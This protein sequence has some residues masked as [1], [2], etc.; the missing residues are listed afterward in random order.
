[1]VTVQTTLVIAI[2]ILHLS[3]GSSQLP[4]VSSSSASSKSCSWAI[5][6]AACGVQR[7]PPIGTTVIPSFSSPPHLISVHPEESWQGKQ[8]WEE[9]NLF[10]TYLPVEF[11]GG[12]G[13]GKNC[14]VSPFLPVFQRA[15]SLF[16]LLQ[17]TM[18]LYLLP[19]L[20]AVHSTPHS[21]PVLFRTHP[22]LPRHFRPQAQTVQVKKLLLG[23][24]EDWPLLLFWRKKQNKCLPE[25]KSKN[26]DLDL[27][28][29]HTQLRQPVLRN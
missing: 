15:N 13:Q 23:D 5:V 20:P 25:S 6:G 22:M 14:S 4:A 3:L 24:T 21:C 9:T 7:N 17:S 19:L 28:P 18:H 10:L 2:H 1:M 29:S 12:K 27:C 16:P 8:L 11:G 26:R